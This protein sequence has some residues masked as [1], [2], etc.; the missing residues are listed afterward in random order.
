MK[1]AAW[2]RGVWGLKQVSFRTGSKPALL[3]VA[4]KRL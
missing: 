2:G 4:I 1:N 3:N